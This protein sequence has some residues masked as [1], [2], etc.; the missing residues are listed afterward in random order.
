MQTEE[1]HPSFVPWTVRDVWWG[2]AFLGLWLVLFMAVSLLVRFSGLDVN[3]GVLIGLAELALLVPVWWLTV[4]KY[5]VE[6]AALGLQ[7]FKGAMLGLGCGLMLLSFAFNL[8]YSFFLALFNLRAQVDLVPIFT[9]L[10]SPWWLLVAGVVVA[11]VVEEVFFRGFVFAGLCRRYNWQK[12]A[13]ISSA[14]FAAQLICWP[15]WTCRYERKMAQFTSLPGDQMP[16]RSCR[17]VGSHVRRLVSLACQI[18]V[19]CEPL[20][21]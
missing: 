7:E 15:T 20:P 5:G 3:V 13:L 11:P 10:S 9:E 4:R 12:A 19:T 18:T 21:N 14:L 6:W 17:E 2:V 1:F 16:S 8:A